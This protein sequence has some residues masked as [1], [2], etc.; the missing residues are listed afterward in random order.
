M[1]LDRARYET[2]LGQAHRAIY[3]AHSWADSMNDEG[4]RE[5]LYQMMTLLQ[6]MLEDS[7]RSRKRTTVR[8]LSGQTTVD[9]QIRAARMDCTRTQA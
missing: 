6:S 3:N 8:P 7:L 4:A 5:D 2:A 1:N 9:E